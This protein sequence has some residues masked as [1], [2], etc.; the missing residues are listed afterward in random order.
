MRSLEA[1][2][3]R[4]GFAELNHA[5]IERSSTNPSLVYLLMDKTGH[6]VSGS[7]P[8]SPVKIGDRD[9]A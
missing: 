3:A 7:I 8:Q 6:A 4:G 9:Q 5:V 1:V 2:Y